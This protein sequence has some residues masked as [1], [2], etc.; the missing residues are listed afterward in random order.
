MRMVRLG[1]HFC[2]RSLA[3]EQPG[4]Q[5]ESAGNVLGLPAEARMRRRGGLPWGCPSLSFGAARGP[6]APLRASFAQ[7]GAER[8]SHSAPV[9]VLTFSEGSAKGRPSFHPQAAW[10]RAGLGVVEH[11]PTCVP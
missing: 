9:R 11:L 2:C 8:S 3:Q 1:G 7:L 6:D 4:D 5:A 10:G